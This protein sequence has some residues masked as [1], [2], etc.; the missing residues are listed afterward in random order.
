MEE[1]QFNNLVEQLEALAT[2]MTT[3]RANFKKEPKRRLGDAARLKDWLDTI[4]EVWSE[5]EEKNDII[6]E[7]QEQLKETNYY[8]KNGTLKLSSNTTTWQQTLD[9]A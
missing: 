4:Q 9:S 5:I 3:K 1:Q 8:K 6:L 2:K 7:H